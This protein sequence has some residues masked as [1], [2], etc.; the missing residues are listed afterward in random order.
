MT[1]AEIRKLR[2]QKKISL[3]EMAAYTG[4]PEAYIE[5]IEDGLVIPL[6]S[7]LERLFQCRMIIRVLGA[8]GM[9]MG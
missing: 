8:F 5:K 7:D 2:L 9:R 4:L 3:L 6:E 1:P